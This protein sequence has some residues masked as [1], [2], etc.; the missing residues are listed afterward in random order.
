MEV[1]QD[2]GRLGVLDGECVYSK[3]SKL[4]DYDFVDCYLT[5]QV[6]GRGQ[7]GAVICLCYDMQGSDVLCN[8]GV[9]LQTH[10]IH[11]NILYHWPPIS[12]PIPNTNSLFLYH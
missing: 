3:Q 7:H 10:N 1:D 5:E 12:T 9:S 4:Q 6:I 2:S 8:G 11:T